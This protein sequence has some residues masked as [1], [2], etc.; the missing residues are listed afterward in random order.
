M[1]DIKSREQK[2]RRILKKHGCYLRKSRAETSGYMI[3]TEIDE[4]RGGEGLLVGHDY[5]LTLEDAE[6][7]AKDM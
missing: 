3:T 7:Y 2:L 6:N 4:G 1:M 5:S